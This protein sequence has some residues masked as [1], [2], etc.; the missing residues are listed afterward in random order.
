MFIVKY[1]KIFLSIGAIAILISLILLIT[2]GL[3]LGSDFTGGAITE[4]TFQERLDQ[5]DLQK[6]IESLGIV[7]GQ[8]Q[9]SGENSYIIRT[10]FLN[11]Q[12]RSSL[13]TLLIDKYGA[14]VERSSSVGPVISREL[15]SKSLIGIFLSVFVTIIFI[16][17]VFRGVRNEKDNLDVGVSS[18]VYGMVAV[19]TLL[20][21]IVVPAGIFA[22]LGYFAGVEID[23][24]FIMALLSILGISI[25]DTIVVFDRIRENLHKNEIAHIREDFGETV[26]R[27]LKE[28]FARSFNTSFT[29]VLVLFSLLFL[30]GES[31]KYFILAL[32]IGMVAGIYSSLFIACPLLVLVA[33]RKDKKT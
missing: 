9:S 18:W 2:L 14:V 28:T 31:T 25:N 5:V 30:G 16:A 23:I 20:H 21:D 17:F 33:E 29:V 15:V 8:V 3:K 13:N 24:L 26:G 22:L 7:G 11:E 12:E 27:S 19:I 1:K 32:T 6:E 4:V 10:R